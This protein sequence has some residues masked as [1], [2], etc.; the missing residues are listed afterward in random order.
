MG[1]WQKYGDKLQAVREELASYIQ[2]YE[3][4]YPVA[5]DAAHEEL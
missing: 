2:E 1:K 3:Q 5:K 4:R